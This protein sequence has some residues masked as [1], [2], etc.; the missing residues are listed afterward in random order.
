MQATT[1]EEEKDFYS[2][3]EMLSEV[4]YLLE[5]VDGR[6]SHNYEDFRGDFKIEKIG[7]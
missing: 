3:E 5:Y 7:G 2:D 1:N 6:C 4:F